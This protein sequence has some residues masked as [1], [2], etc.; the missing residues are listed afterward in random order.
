MNKKVKKKEK[1]AL[2]FFR[3]LN[4][5]VFTQKRMNLR[6]EKQDVLTALLLLSIECAD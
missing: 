6:D 2:E 1:K 3:L 4:K 5:G